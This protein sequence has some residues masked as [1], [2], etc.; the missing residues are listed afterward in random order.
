MDLKESA[1]QWV[2]RNLPHDPADTAVMT[3]LNSLDVSKLLA[4]YHNWMSRL[5]QPTPRKVFLSRAFKQ[6]PI[7]SARQQEISLIIRDVESGNDLI[8]YLSR[9]IRFGVQDP[10]KKR[11]QDLDL[12]LNRWG[13]HHLHV[14]SKLEADGFVERSNEVIFAIFRP[15][16]AFFVDIMNHGDWSRDHVLETIVEEWPTEGLIHQINGI[17]GLSHTLTEVDRMVLHKKHVNSAFEYRGKVYMPDGILSSAG[18]SIHAIREADRVVI[19]VEEF[20]KR[21]AADPTWLP[22]LFQKHGVTYPTNPRFEFHISEQ[23]VGVFEALT[24]TWMPLLG[25]NS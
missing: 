1:R 8:K 12:M 11:R 22:S 2:L 25:Q 7:Y 9:G 21:V 13:V 23:G 5:V 24:G 3:R 18:T 17:A 14:S 10:A 15:E 19:A 4:L 6:N 20:E 16:K